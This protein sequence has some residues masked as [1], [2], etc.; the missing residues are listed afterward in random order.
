[1]M[2]TLD[3]RVIDDFDWQDNYRGTLSAFWENMQ[4]MV[5]DGQ[6]ASYIQEHYV[7]RLFPQASEKELQ[8]RAM[9]LAMN[10]YNA[11]N[12]NLTSAYPHAVHQESCVVISEGEHGPYREH[13]A[14]AIFSKAT[15]QYD[16]NIGLASDLIRGN[17]EEER[18]SDT[19]NLYVDD[20]DGFIKAP[21]PIIHKAIIR[22]DVDWDA[23]R[24][25]VSHK[26]FL[27]ENWRTM[28][29]K[30]F[31]E[32]IMEITHNRHLGVFNALNTLRNEMSVFYDPQ[33]KIDDALF[34]GEVE[35]LPV[36]VNK[37]REIQAIVPF[38]S[39]GQQKI[40]HEIFSAS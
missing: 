7:R 10:T 27:P 24:A 9:L 3:E 8:E 39:L 38:Y 12:L 21:V 13:S 31:E 17:R 26:N 15:A 35:I 20:K 23:V 6:L 34:D 33:G 30:E 32:H 18:I 40:A 36:L 1:M 29:N 11:Y 2:Q 19:T 37:R 5:Q 25:I 14:F 28:T 22:E 16:E 4:A